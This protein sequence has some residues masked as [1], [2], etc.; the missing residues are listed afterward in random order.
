MFWDICSNLYCFH[1]QTW[2]RGVTGA[3]LGGGYKLYLPRYWSGYNL[4]LHTTYNLQ[5]SKTPIQH[6][7]TLVEIDS[8]VH[9][10]EDSKESDLHEQE[11]YW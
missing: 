10:E 5:H 11:K 4:Y 3:N 6:I 1:E 8:P 2:F 9:V 7:I